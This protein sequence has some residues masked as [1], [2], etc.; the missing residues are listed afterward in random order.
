[1]SV[2]QEPQTRRAPA[3]V[4]AGIDWATEDHA[5]AIVASIV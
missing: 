4:T 2:E 1:M 3:R 5:V